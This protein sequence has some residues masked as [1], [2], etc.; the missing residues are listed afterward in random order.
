MNHEPRNL[1]GLLLELPS[2]PIQRAD[3]ADLRG[4]SYQGKIGS[5]A[6]ENFTFK[7]Q[8]ALHHEDVT[9]S[10]P[11]YTYPVICRRSGTRLLALSIGREVIE[12]LMA[13]RMGALSDLRMRRV[14]I[15][16]DQLV[17]NLADRPTD[18]ALSF[19]HA[20]APAFGASLRSLSFYGDDLA[21]AALFRD[22][23]SLMVFFTC[24]IREAHGGAEVLR[25]GHDG[26]IS[27]QYTSQRRILEVERVLTFLREQG[28]FASDLWSGE[29]DR[30]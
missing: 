24:G 15:G 18:Y 29:G 20:R 14:S 7:S 9:A 8:V 22:H 19:A 11:P 5:S 25:L 3:I 12:Y 16:V 26:A 17:K 27:F 13:E 6:W 28:Y 4:L 30:P 23:L 21:E 10:N 1:S 2:R